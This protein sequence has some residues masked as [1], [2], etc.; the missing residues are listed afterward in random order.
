MDEAV[1]VRSYA[2][3][4]KN[5]SELKAGLISLYPFTC[6][7]HSISVVEDTH[8]QGENKTWIN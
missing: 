7:S 8:K 5:S 6:F 4:T 3:N 2:S 1:N